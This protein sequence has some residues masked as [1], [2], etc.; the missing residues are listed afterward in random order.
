MISDSPDWV[1][2]GHAPSTVAF[3]NLLWEP[4]AAMEEIWLLWGHHVKK[5]R[6]DREMLKEFQLFRFF[7]VQVPDPTRATF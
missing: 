7:L 3:R 6:G 4:S 1:R 2:K 5:P